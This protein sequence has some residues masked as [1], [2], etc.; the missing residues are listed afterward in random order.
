MEGEDEFHRSRR[1]FCI[2]EGKLLLGPVDTSDS[3][4]QW[5]KKEGWSD[6]SIDELTRGFVSEK[7]E[8]YF[9]VGL[10]FEVTEKAKKEMF[11]HLLELRKKLDLD[12]TAHL[13]GG[14]IPQPYGGLWPPRKD[15]GELGAI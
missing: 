10:D 3:H 11:A 5:F 9:Y 6:S 8:V 1:M 15:Y 13:Y 2:K 4:T 7:G 12:K 14:M